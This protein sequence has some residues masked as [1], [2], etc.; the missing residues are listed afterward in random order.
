MDPRT[1]FHSSTQ[2]Y[3]NSEAQSQHSPMPPCEPPTPK[4]SAAADANHLPKTTPMTQADLWKRTGSFS[5]HSAGLCTGRREAG[6]S[7]TL[8][9]ALGQGTRQSFPR[10]SESGGRGSSQDERLLGEDPPSRTQPV[11]SEAPP[12]GHCWVLCSPA[13]HFPRPLCLS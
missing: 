12:R 6:F 11:A 10:E 8:L 7:W 2:Q 9:G 3:S 4:V 1:I 5:S 13:L